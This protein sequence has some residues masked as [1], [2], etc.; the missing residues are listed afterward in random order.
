MIEDL[1]DPQRREGRLLVV[2]SLGEFQERRSP[3]HHV[4][5]L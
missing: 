4:D 3:F 5:M 1:R 2:H